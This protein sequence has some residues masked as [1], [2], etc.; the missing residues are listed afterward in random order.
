MSVDINSLPDLTEYD[1]LPEGV[2][3]LCLRAVAE[4]FGRSQGCGTRSR[5]CNK[6]KQYVEEVQKGHWDAEV[7]IDG[8]FVMPAVD[9][10]EDIDLILVLPPD[11]DMS[12]EVKPYEYNLISCR[13]TRKHYGF[14]VFAVR[15]G[16]A[17]EKEWLEFFQQ[18]NVKWCEPLGI[19]PGTPKGIVRVAHDSE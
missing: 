7:I 19:P 2:H 9:D 11:W 14:D 4:Y 17:E 5:L 16:S 6:L 18:V 13:R 1:L 3:P 10:P 8:S 12:A 15:S